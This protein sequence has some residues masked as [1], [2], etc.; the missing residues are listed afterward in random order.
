[1]SELNV[2][3]DEVLI[4]IERLTKERGS[5]GF[6]ISDMAEET[7]RT[8]EWCRDKLGKMIRAGVAQCVG[9]TTRPA[10]DGTN[11]NIPA[12]AIVKKLSK[13]NN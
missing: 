8:K 4:E 3:F 1:M 5:S 12:Y 7:G 9:R 10:I 6:T 11:R 13:K 2:S